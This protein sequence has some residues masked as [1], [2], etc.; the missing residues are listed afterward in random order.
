[1]LPIISIWPGACD[2]LSPGDTPTRRIRRRPAYPAPAAVATVA[3]AAEP[4]AEQVAE[5]G[6]EGAEPAASDEA[7]AVPAK[8]VAPPKKI[9]AVRGDDRPGMKK[10]EPAGRDERRGPGGRDGRGDRGGFGGRGDN[11]DGRDSRGFEREPREARGP[12]LGDAAFRA[13]REALEAALALLE[14]SEWQAQL[15]DHCGDLAH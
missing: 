10:A 5:S 9:V 1:M 13:Q 8:P 12:R 7:P 11:R 14:S 2:D 15:S 3:P 6:A 4:A